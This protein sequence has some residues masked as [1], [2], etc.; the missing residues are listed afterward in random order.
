[1]QTH[2]GNLQSEAKDVPKGTQKKDV[3]KG[4]TVV[5]KVDAYDDHLKY[6]IYVYA[7]EY[8]VYKK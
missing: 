6:S 5:V 2:I 3:P 1:L 4:D 7:L 8:E